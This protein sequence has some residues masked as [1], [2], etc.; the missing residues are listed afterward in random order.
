LQGGGST[1]IAIAFLAY[2]DA[3]T[4]RTFFKIFT[5]VVIFGLYYG[6]FFLPV[7]LSIFKPKPYYIVSSENILNETELELINVESK[8]KIRIVPQNGTKLNDIS[9]RKENDK[10]NST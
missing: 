9:D 1:A 10:I 4:F 2:S 3:Y 8:K 6:I 5:I 7:I